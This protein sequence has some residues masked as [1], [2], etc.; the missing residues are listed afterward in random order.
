[1]QKI[2]KN[3]RRANAL[4]WHFRRRGGD[5]YAFEQRA[6]DLQ[7]KI[8][9]R[10]DPT[11]PPAGFSSWNRFFFEQQQAARIRLKSIGKMKYES[12]EFERN[13]TI[14]EALANPWAGSI[15]PAIQEAQRSLETVPGSVKVFTCDL[16]KLR[17]SC[18]RD[19]PGEWVYL[20]QYKVSAE[21][22][23]EAAEAAEVILK[24]QGFDLAGHVYQIG[25]E[26]A[27]LHSVELPF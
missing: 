10:L 12:E 7:L 13:Y 23:V 8:R 6:Y 24:A 18:D 22:W 1:M 4:Y 14:G 27:D 15:S 2:I 17:R 9:E 5:S 25:L 11:P 20:T 3:L 26:D 19:Q 16:Y 21:S